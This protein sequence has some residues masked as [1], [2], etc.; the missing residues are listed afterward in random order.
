MSLPEQDFDG[1]ED[2][3]GRP[4]RK[5]WTFWQIVA[6]VYLYVWAGLILAAG[7]AAFASFIIYDQVIQPGTPG[8]AI[9]VTVPTGT[10]GQEAGKILERSGLVEDEGFF[11]LALKFDSSKRPIKS[12]IHDLPQGLSALELLH[13]LQEG[14]VRPIPEEQVRIT[15]PEGLSLQQMAALFDDP[16]GFIE[17]ASDPALVAR[18]GLSAPNLEGF[19][20]PETYFFE[21]KPGMRQAIER[22]LEQ[23]EKSYA[24]LVQA[25]PGAEKFDKMGVVTVA[26]LVEEEAKLD[27]ERPLVAAV[28]YNRIDEG[29]PLQMDSTLQF[30]LGKYGQ[31][32]LDTD[33]EIDSPYNTYRNK[34]LPP[35]PISCPGKASLKA[36]LQ[37]AAVDYLYFVSNADGKSHTFSSTDR[38]HQEAVARF[39][40]EIA[41]QRRAQ[42][43]A[44]QQQ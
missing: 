19:L 13:R 16:K 39:R 42:E 23:F 24:E 22:M 32:M 12:G 3:P 40:R 35:G 41:P 27:D 6:R 28:L 1:P 5:R 17:A 26:S 31:R 18:L 44:A 11:R 7:V 37:P 34:G 43:E 33:K 38:E 10:T 29:M 8:P 30:A 4:A 2:A 20:M 9:A 15:I 21:K 14:P 36:A 25:T